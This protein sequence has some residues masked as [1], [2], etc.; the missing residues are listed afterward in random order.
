MFV[1]EI[2]HSCLSTSGSFISSGSVLNIHPLPSPHPHPRSLCLSI[3]FFLSFSPLHSF[4]PSLSPPVLSLDNMQHLELF[5][6]LQFQRISAE[7]LLEVKWSGLFRDD[8]TPG[9]PRLHLGLGHKER[10]WGGGW[11]WWGVSY[12]GPDRG[13]MVLVINSLCLF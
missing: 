11:G 5:K 8:G 2:P 6:R 3:S 12:L 7:R 9:S 13:Q 10:G 4:F 1:L